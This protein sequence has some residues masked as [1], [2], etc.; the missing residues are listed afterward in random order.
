MRITTQNTGRSRRDFLRAGMYGV[1]VSA[2]MPAFLQQVAWAAEE[3]ASLNQEQHGN[4]IMVVLELAGGNDGLNTFVPYADDAYYE[5]RPKLAIP[6]NQV[7]KLN[8]QLGLHPACTGL[9]SLFKDGQLAVIQ[10]CGYPNPNL[11]HFTAM[12]WWHT[13]TPHG[14]DEYGWIGRFADKHQPEAIENYI[15]NIASRQSFAVNS[16]VHSPVVFTNPNKFG[17]V[18]TEAQ[19]KVFEVFGEIEPTKNNALDFVNQVS[20]TA[21]TGAAMVRN[22]CAEYKTMVDYGSNNDLTADLKKVSAMIAADL[23]TRIYY[24]SMGGF[25]THATQAGAHQTLMIYLSDAI[26]GFIADIERLGRAD[27]VSMMVFTE[28]GRRVGENAS[29]GTDHGTATP[30]YI[31]GKNV[32]GGFYGEHPSLTDLDDGNLKMTT[33]FRSVYGTM[34]SEWMGFDQTAKVLKGDF[35]TFP[36]FG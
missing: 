4:R 2:A 15:V 8:D 7:L 25:D 31:L 20:K 9:E 22:A 16:G 14:S 26:R 30:M 24:V 33:D 35:P 36:V 3:K 32:K 5:A 29:G 23:P 27:D 13:A 6:S 21:T 28:F 1:G 19:Q 34:L 11:S 10:G 12:E 18:G 17:R